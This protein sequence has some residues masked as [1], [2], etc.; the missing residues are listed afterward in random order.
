MAVVEAGTGRVVSMQPIGKG[1]D[2][3]DRK[4]SGRNRS[5]REWTRP[6]TIRASGAHGSRSQDWQGVPVG[7][8][9]RAASRSGTGKAA[10]Q[11]ADDSWNLWCFGGR[12]VAARHDESRSWLALWNNSPP[13]ASYTSVPI[14][15]RIR[16]HECA[17][18]KED[19]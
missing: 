12:K 5:E 19:L 1:V 17:T 18:L 2:A 7:C 4:G 13:S 11:S 16:A 8:G 10:T 9:V 3:T 6:S 15:M 14:V